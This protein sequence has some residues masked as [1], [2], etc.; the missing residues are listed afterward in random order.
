MKEEVS[1][2]QRCDLNIFGDC[3]C[4]LGKRFHTATV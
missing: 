1:T 3:A 2:P 4:Y